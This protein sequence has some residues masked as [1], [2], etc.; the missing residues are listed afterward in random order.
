MNL[1][2][3]TTEQRNPASANIDKCST[4]EMVKI[5]NDEDKK[6]AGAIE[7]VL[8]QMTATSKLQV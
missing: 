4:P 3:L 7:K 5:I 1:G 6:I 8:P 2:N